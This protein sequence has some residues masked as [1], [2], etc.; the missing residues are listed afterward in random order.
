MWAKYSINKSRQKLPKS[1]PLWLVW[2]IHA[3]PNQF[4]TREIHMVETCRLGVAQKSL[5][6][7][8]KSRAFQHHLFVP[9][10][11][12]QMLTPPSFFWNGEISFCET[13]IFSLSVSLHTDESLALVREKSK[14]HWIIFI[15]KVNKRFF[16]SLFR[17]H[18]F[19]KKRVS[20]LI[21]CYFFL[22]KLN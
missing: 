1:Q 8:L 10:S 21:F 22:P 7:C 9:K 5:G 16:F 2:Q 14:Y 20:N 4:H 6:K 17:K 3:V 13:G 12:K 18:S 19:Q 11:Q 15:F